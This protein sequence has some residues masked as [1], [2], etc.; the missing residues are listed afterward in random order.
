M[1]LRCS[2]EVFLKLYDSFLKL[3]LASRFMHGIAFW[4]F[5]RPRVDVDMGERQFITESAS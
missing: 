3:A 4:R 5:L 1:G 2:G